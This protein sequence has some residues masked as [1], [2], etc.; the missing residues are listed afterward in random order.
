MAGLSENRKAL[1]HY[2]EAQRIDTTC[3][4]AFYNCANVRHDL[5]DIEGAARNY[6][7]VVELN[8]KHVDAFYN[9]GTVL[10]AASNFVDAE[11]AYASANKITKGRDKEVAD[12][13]RLC[14]AARALKG[15]AEWPVRV[16]IPGRQ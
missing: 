13:L 3:V 6:Q 8:P 15:E 5:G 10:Q 2:G 4:V 9:L 7:R 14:R 11:R 1:E 12:A 16:R